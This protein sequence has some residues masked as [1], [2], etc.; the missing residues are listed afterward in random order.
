MV[1]FL[2]QITHQ[3]LK[4]SQTMMVFTLTVTFDVYLH[5]SVE[6]LQSI[7]MRSYKYE[8]VRG[9]F[10]R[11]LSIIIK[12]SIHTYYPQ[13]GATWRTLRWTGLPFRQPIK[14]F[15]NNDCCLSTK[16]EILPDHIQVLF[17]AIIYNFFRIWNPATSVESAIN[18]EQMR[19]PG[20][21]WIFW[22]TH[23]WI[24]YSMKSTKQYFGIELLL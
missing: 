20:E 18:P 16:A 24:N 17:R 21:K 5:L 19:M 1:E 22:S 23:G 7:G 13:K 12:P 4:S 15:I 10:V 8:W 11:N 2:P 14:G 3:K 9:M 6:I